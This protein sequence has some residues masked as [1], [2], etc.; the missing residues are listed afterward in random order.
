[1][2]LAAVGKAVRMDWSWLLES[3]CRLVLR[4]VFR[5]VVAKGRGNNR[6]KR[7]RERKRDWGR[8]NTVDRLAI[9]GKILKYSHLRHLWS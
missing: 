8:K 1:M 2:E 5:S 7:A 6:E 3:W 9:K 4:R